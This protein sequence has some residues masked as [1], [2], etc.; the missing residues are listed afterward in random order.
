METGRPIRSVLFVRCPDEL[1]ERL[2]AAAKQSL[3]SLNSE[4]VYRL[5]ESLNQPA[6]KQAVTR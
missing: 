3:R 1:R 2:A 6:T 5:K 4:A